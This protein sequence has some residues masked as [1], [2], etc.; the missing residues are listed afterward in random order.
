[1]LETMSKPPMLELVIELRFFSPESEN[2][3][4]GNLEKIAKK[5]G[6]NNI[7]NLGIANLPNEIKEKDPNL[8][9]APWYRITHSENKHLFCF[10]GPKMFSVS[11]SKD[12]LAD[13]IFFPGWSQSLSNIFF[14]II[15]D[16]LTLKSMLNIS[17]DNVK[18][19]TIDA[20]A[21]E[22]GILE[23]SNL[24]IN[25]HTSNLLEKNKKTTVIFQE[26]INELSHTITISNSAQL[27][28]QLTGSQF[29]GSLIDITT[30]SLLSKEDTQTKTINEIIQ[31]C[32]D[33]N[34]KMFSS[35]L[36]QDYAE[37]VLGATYVK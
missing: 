33:E 7:E 12:V 6:F 10:I 22:N 18:Y 27:I 20:F 19:R 2:L 4:V 36:K 9:Y 14:T 28:S 16:I 23:K 35:I 3:I 31:F 37:K 25:L 24:I 11:W 17:F 13:S 29:K 1:M 21:E 34:K 30:E 5:H 15:S 8:H 26:N 32:H